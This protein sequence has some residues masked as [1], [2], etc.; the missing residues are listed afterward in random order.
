MADVEVFIALLAGVVGLVWLAG[1]ARVPYPV[2]LVVGGLGAGLL[3]FLP[4]VRVDPDA[5]LLVFLPP[6]VYF[7]AFEFSDEDTRMQ[8]TPITL[9]AVPLVLVTIG[10]VAWVAHAVT[11]LSWA[12]AFTLGAILGPTDPVAATSVV[13]SMG[14]SER[15]ATMLEGESLVNDGT[16]I[17]AFRV[18]VGVAGGEAFH[19]GGAVLEFAGVAAGG[20]A[21]GAV[22]GW[23]SAQLRRRL[24]APQLEI[25][26][27]LLTAYGAFAGAER[28][29]L[30]GILAAVTAGFVVGRV[31]GIFSPQGRLQQLG[32]WAAVSF[33]AE[34]LLFLLVG[35]AFA[36]VA[37]DTEGGI[38]TV[39][40]QAV[41]LGAIVIGL[42]LLWVFTV[43]YLR[44]GE[45][46]TGKRERFII[47]VG[48]MRGAV[49]VALA[50]AVPT[51]VA[52]RDEILL[53]TSGTVLVTLVP[54]GAA[55]PWLVRRL[56]L[57]ETDDARRRY[58]E[59]R[60]HLARAALEKADTL[61]APEALVARAREAYELRIARLRHSVEDD[62][63]GDD[64]DAYRRIRQALLQAEQAA[65]EEL[66]VSG[67]TLR[68]V[69]HDLDL[70]A[71]RL[72]R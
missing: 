5:V 61:D 53:L 41:L 11:G 2:L 59:T 29:H 7:A 34:S 65:L 42:R 67:D 62:P 57:I 52:G 69:R 27:A 25:T 9:L 8:W 16:G 64:A 12:A 37:G 24:D 55:L 20:I 4:D 39:L 71:S 14:G 13:R 72:E 70:E 33:L 56:G 50:L 21:L 31:P 43:P 3:P 60:E 10:A 18:A 47:G 28:L 66:D 58:V 6:I 35:L 40:A 48:G 54:I 19:V 46:V 63:A 30:S 26:V 23:V 45:R 1:P 38:G 51:D 32:F 49:S 22:V 15:M 44:R 68:E 17:T 36:D